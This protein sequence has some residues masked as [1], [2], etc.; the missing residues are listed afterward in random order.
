MRHQPETRT[1]DVGALLENSLYSIDYLRYTVFRQDYALDFGLRRRLRAADAD[2][3]PDCGPGQTAK[4]EWFLICLFKSSTFFAFG[5]R[6][7]ATH[8]RIRLLC[9][10]DLESFEVPPELWDYLEIYATALFTSEYLLR[11]EA[12]AYY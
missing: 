3:S 4:H 11:R 5:F 8:S 6:S 7:R 1:V 12:A 10:R 9:S 2:R